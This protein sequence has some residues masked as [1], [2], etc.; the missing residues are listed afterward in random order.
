[1][2]KK[3]K[4]TVGYWYGMSLHMGVCHGPVDS[5]LDISQDDRPILD[6]PINS[7]EV[8]AIN[9]GDLFGGKKREGGLDGS[10]HAMFG[11]PD[12]VVLGTLL[13]G[14]VGPGVHQPSYR[15]ILS[16]FFDGWI[17]ANN[18]YIKPF[19]A[20]VKRIVQG[21]HGGTAWYSTASEIGSDMNP[22]HIIYQTHTDPSWGMGYPTS[23]IDDDNF[24]DVAS[25]LR[26]EGFGLSLLW[27]QQVSIEEFHG[28]I[29]DHI[30]GVLRTNPRTGKFEIKL[31]RADYTASSLPEFTPSNCTLENFQRAAATDTINE[32]T[33][34][35]TNNY[36]ET[37]ITVHNLANIQQQG[38]VISKT[39]H[40]PGITQPAIAA[41]VAARD[42]R[43]LSTP[44]AKIRL[45]TNRRAWDI[46]PGDCIRLTW[47]KL[48]LDGVVFRVLK[49]S[50]GD[51][52]SGK[53]MV[54]A[55]EDIY[56]LP[57]ASYV[58][59]ED[60]GWVDPGADPVASPRRYVAEAPYW[61]L[62]RELSAADLAY[63][64]STDCYLSVT[65]Q[66]P[67]GDAFEPTLWTRIS[68]G[69]YEEI[70]QG[71]HC[72][73][74]IL[75]GDHAIN[76]ATLN[77]RDSIDLSLVETGG[78]LVVNGECMRIDAV[79]I[80]TETVTV[81]P[82]VLDTVPKAHVDGEVVFFVDGFQSSDGIEYATGETVQVRIQTQTTRGELDVDTAPQDS[83]VMAGRQARPYP[84]GNF[85]INGTAYPASATVAGGTITVTWAH[86]D[87]LQQT[88]TIIA[89][90]TGNIGPEAGTT[91]NLRAYA[92]STLLQSYTGLTGTSQAVTVLSTVA[93]LHFDGANAS[94]TFSDDTGNTWT[95][96]GNA[97]ISTAQSVF[98]GSS[99]LFD[100]TGDY[101]TTPHREAYSGL[102]DFTVEARIFTNVNNAV[103]CIA[104]KGTTGA[105]TGWWFSL[106]ASGRLTFNMADATGIMTCQ[107][108]TTLATGT[109]YMVAAVKIGSVVTVYLNGVADGTL[110]LPRTPATNTLTMVIG[111]DSVS[112][113]RDWNGH[114]DELRLSVVGRYAGTYSDPGAAFSLAADSPPASVRIELES[115]RSSLTS[116]Q[117]HSHTVALT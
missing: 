54:D 7:S 21:W 8:R 38:A 36:R 104:K 23:S 16:L 19:S 4:V 70:G 109:W 63:I 77:L 51:L 112:A 37:P 79:D 83:L 75:D 43:A 92:G 48:G 18:P 28:I 40:Y 9:K 100:G 64:T 71:Q 84:P 95:R 5:I 115:V 116:W 56:G 82:G 81:S 57:T 106:D 85:R 68:G 66:K 32:L 98:G 91:Y 111:R 29:M 78:Y 14:A 3:K 17:S 46:L 65:S 55:A 59:Q 103:K 60:V 22:A 73:V 101:I 61:D 69:T 97:Q 33:V 30:G 76:A 45:S 26:T 41:R 114:I 13:Q 31:I 62:T 27:T 1:M 87:R 35:Y 49:V 105:T 88:A 47:P 11:G 102:T 107:G 42:L 74:A 52:K 89:Q 58:E 110:A 93:L 94:I 80:A 67:S 44:V 12:Q 34:V 90:S 99:G 113:T 2:G 6:A 20:V 108:A 10:L 117:T 39:V 86:R 72:P 15:G 96:V 50:L 25:T 24:R 53:I